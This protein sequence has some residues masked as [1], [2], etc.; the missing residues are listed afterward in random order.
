MSNRF[1]NFKKRDANTFNF[2]CPY[3]GDSK[4]KKR[5]ARGYIYK[6][7][8]FV[9]YFCHNC[10]MS[11]GFNGFLKDQD[12]RLYLEYIKEKFQNN[13]FEAKP[14]KEEKPKPVPL[15]TFDNLKRIADLDLFHP[16]RKYVEKRGIP[17]DQMQ[18]L[19][20]APR[21]KWWTNTLMPGFF[22]DLD[23]D[24]PRLIIP[25]VDKESVRGYSGRSFDPNTKLRYISIKLDH[26]KDK[27]FGLDKADLHRRFYVVEGPLDSLFLDNCI[28]TA[29]GSLQIGDLDNDNAVYVW[30]N[31]PRNP[32]VAKQVLKAIE[33]GKKVVI[34]PKNIQQ[35]DLNEM[36]LAG[37]KVKKI[38]SSNT[39]KG[40]RA[41]LEYTR[42]TS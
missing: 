5:L 23:K 38:V 30:D 17:A 34:W 14:E 39:F 36:V 12:H 10:M 16:A 2:S 26:S 33:Q 42:W 35:K 32:H 15:T 1:R 29:D 19:F 11:L 40:A 18:R 27:I 25:N 24:E 21:F 9:K 8:G 6:K 4:K 22:N 37:V 3:C 41:M 13:P 31:Q 20:Y 28:A 7:K